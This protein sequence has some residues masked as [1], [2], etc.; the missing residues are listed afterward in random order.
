M[1]LPAPRLAR[2]FLPPRPAT[3][4][5][6]ARSRQWVL[7]FAP[8]EK[9]RL[10]PLMGWAGSGDTMKQ[11]TLE[12]PTKEAAIAYCEARAISY[13]VEPVPA[14]PK[15]KPK[16]YADNFRYGRAENWSH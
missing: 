12:F 14:D 2:I 13:E 7:Q 15:M 10:D 3:Q 6:H 4:S 1:S 8:T 9:L 16:V 11:V 5:G